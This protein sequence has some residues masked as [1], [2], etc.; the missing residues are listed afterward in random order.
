MQKII[1]FLL[2]PVFDIGFMAQILLPTLIILWQGPKRDKFWI[3]LVGFS[4]LFLLS[5]WLIP[6]RPFDNWNVPNPWYSII[7]TLGYLTHFGVLVI[8]MWRIF[9]MRLSSA[10]FGCLIAYN[11][12]HCT[13][14][15]NKIFEISIPGYYDLWVLSMGIQ[16][17]PNAL[18][19][20]FINSSFRRISG[21]DIKNIYVL[22][23]TLLGLA[24][25]VCVSSF[26]VISNTA[27]SPFTYYFLCVSIICCLA[28]L[29]LQAFNINQGV[30]TR[31]LQ[32]TRLLWKEDRH[33]YKIQKQNQE[34][35]NMKIH[36]MKHFLHMFEGK[37]DQEVLDK[38]EEILHGRQFVSL[39]ET[40][41]LPLDVVLNFKNQECISKGIQFNFSGDGKL[42]SF[43]DES[44]VYALFGNIIDN[45]IEAVKDLPKEERIINVSFFSEIGS[46]IISSENYFTGNL[47]FGKNHQL[48]TTKAHK[49]GHGYGI[50][51]IKYIAEKYKGG[52]TYH[53]ENNQFFLTALLKISNK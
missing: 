20:I 14:C 48:L 2:N 42:I 33:N 37:V 25:N 10:L 53:T 15:I 51:S 40:S 39:Y 23:V 27:E 16:W 26:A 36:D 31:K 43:M 32:E 34:E 22:I 38:M 30:I 35:F 18:F 52:V 19:A 4:L 5:S 46:V 3:R 47:S 50:A 9:D 17:I 44:D 24:A 29:A 13:Y 45:A 6:F 1:G 8:C 7:T 41:C 21:F 12:Q 28:L 11:I 49:K